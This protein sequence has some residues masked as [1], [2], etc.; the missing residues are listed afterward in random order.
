[1]NITPEAREAAN[2]E[3]AEVFSLVFADEKNNARGHFV[4]LA[5]NAAVAEKDREIERLKLLCADHAT[6][7]AIAESEVVQMG[8]KCAGM[9]EERDT[10]TARLA[11]LQEIAEGFNKT[12]NQYVP[13][14]YT[15]N[16]SPSIANSF[17]NLITCYNQWK[18]KNEK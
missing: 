16:S 4:Q 10:L 7:Q 18:E 14:G 12:A 17:R 13:N 3:A 11:E 6:S 9:K 15:Q 2:R 1:M 8:Y 5:I